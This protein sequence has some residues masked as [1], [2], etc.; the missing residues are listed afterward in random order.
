MQLYKPGYADKMKSGAYHFN[1]SWE[2]MK[3]SFENLA[4][5][6]SPVLV[7]IFDSLKVLFDA[8]TSDN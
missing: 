2:K 3:A 4:I 1:E 6:A 7:S 5:A 8:A